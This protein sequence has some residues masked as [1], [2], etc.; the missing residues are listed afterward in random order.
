MKKTATPLFLLLIFV[1]QNVQA[2]VP[3][4]V[5]TNGLVAWY[6]FNSS[7]NDDSGNNNHA[8]NNGATYYSDRFGNVGAAGYFNGSNAYMEVQTPSFT[9]SESGNFT[10]SFWVRKEVQPA[11]GIVMMTGVNT[12]GVFITL[13]QGASQTTFGT[14][15]Q[16]SAWAF[17]NAPHT[18][19]VWDHYVASYDAGAMNLYKNGNLEASGT[20]PYNGATAMNVPLYIGKGIGSG[21]FLGGIDDMGIWNRTLNNQEI[22]D[23][24]NNSI[25]G[26]ES[27]LEASASLQIQG[28]PVGNELKIKSMDR[29]AQQSYSIINLMGQTV[30]SGLLEIGDS[31]IGTAK[32]EEGVYIL[33]TSA[34]KSYRFVKVK[35]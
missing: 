35:Q 17:I 22:L 11:A 24:Y 1:L 12:A 7:P 21:N 5:P 27:K 28:N 13:I 30:Q 10:Y 32:L 6:G 2:Q 34:G 25:T 16:Q 19:N 31:S 3:S 26:I 18:L 4:Y 8:V 29:Q 20:Y 14:N 33:Q 9:L 23:L 15:R